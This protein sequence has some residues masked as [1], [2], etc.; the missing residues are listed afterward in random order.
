MHALVLPHDGISVDFRKFLVVRFANLGTKRLSGTWGPSV[1]IT[2][3]VGDGKEKIL[4]RGT[5]RKPYVNAETE[6]S[7]ECKFL[8]QEAENKRPG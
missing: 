5:I 8:I 7:Q 4:H 6:S 1:M 2:Q 3:R